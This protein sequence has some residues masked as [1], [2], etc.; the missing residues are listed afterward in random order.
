M[1]SSHTTIVTPATFVAPI[2]IHFLGIDIAKA[3][4]DVA[5][6]I[7]A[8]DGDVKGKDRHKA[9]VFTNNAAGF[10]QL[11]DWLQTQGVHSERHTVH[12]AMEATGIYW[13]EL[14]QALAGAGLHVSVVNPS[15]IANYSK[16]LLQRGKTDIQDARSIAQY[17]ERE[18]P[19]VWVQAPLAQRQLLALVRQ[20][21]HLTNS[22]QA[23]ACRHQTAQPL[24]K[25]SIEGVMA[26]L[27]R[28]IKALDLLIKQHIDS[29][30]ELK[31]NQDLLE[32]VPGVGCKLSL[33]LL[34][35]LGDG[36]KFQRGKQAAAYA[37]LNPSEWQS[38]SSVN[39]K[40]RISKVGQTDLRKILFM[41]A[42]SVYG[43]HK[44]FTAFVER[45][46]ASGKAPKAIVVALMRK[47]LTIAQAVLKSQTPFNPA[48]HAN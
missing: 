41:P 1:D 22:L 16:S 29:N 5:L 15:K 43:R 44:Q 36:H 48:L 20:H 35:Y 26:A 4:F 31:H 24:V 10:S 11:F 28:S 32:S 14:A 27:G 6:T 47:I 8:A 33:W 40:S 18:R 17:C 45:L 37:G 21:Q 42:L 34:A 19:A 9:K 3:K 30:P 46:K 38:G 2:T 13:E 25:A 23:E 12:C 39:K 7:K